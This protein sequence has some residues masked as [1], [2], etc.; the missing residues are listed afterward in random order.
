M[1]VDRSADEYVSLATIARVTG[2]HYRRIKAWAADR[3]IRTRQLP[4][5]AVRY[6][7]EDARKLVAASEV[8]GTAPAVQK[9]KGGRHDQTFR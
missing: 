4:G 2:S 5:A 3:T 8:A 1:D 6:S 9:R 7:L